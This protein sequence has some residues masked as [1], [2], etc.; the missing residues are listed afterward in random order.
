[1][2]G[3]AVRVQIPMF[4]QMKCALKQNWPITILLMAHVFYELMT[5]DG[6][7]DGRNHGHG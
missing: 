1:M 3:R 4:Q 6:T 5:D 7:D 2:A